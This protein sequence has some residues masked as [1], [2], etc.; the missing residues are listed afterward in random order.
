M[1]RPL[2]TC[3]V[4]QHRVEMAFSNSPPTASY[5]RADG[6]GPKGSDEM[7]PG[8]NRSSIDYDPEEIRDYRAYL[9]HAARNR[10]LAKYR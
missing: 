4:C 7:C 6:T 5:H 1:K 8:F 9:R 10:R 2:A 3:R